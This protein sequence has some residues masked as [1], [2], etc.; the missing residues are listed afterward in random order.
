MTEYDTTTTGTQPGRRV[1]ASRGRAS[2]GGPPLVYTPISAR[3]QDTLQ[4]FPD[5]VRIIRPGSGRRDATPPTRTGSQILGFSAK[6]QARLRFAALNASPAIESTFCLTYHQDWPTQGETCR[7]HRR[8]FL[9]RFARLLPDVGYL[10]LLEF[11]TR[12]A[13]HFHFYLTRLLTPS[14]QSNLA[15]SWVE[16]TNGSDQA[17]WW[18]SRP[19]N[20]RPW[21]ILGG[22]YI[23]K[24]LDKEA[25]KVVPEGYAG[26][27]RFWGTSAGL[28]P[29][30]I[31]MPTST[32]T[33]YDQVDQATGEV[34][35]GEVYLIR[36]LGRLADRKSRGYSR[37]RV[38]AQKSSYTMHGGA[39]AFWRLE[40]YLARSR[41][42]EVNR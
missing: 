22:G 18:H 26:F 10:W 4:V 27:G 40:R 16:I 6:S 25:Q 17:L 38:Q 2:A 12:S 3:D 13:P 31:Q 21:Q 30:P 7:R 32:L 23:C 28:V 29:D 11:Q 39:A 14:E 19:E 36:N 34:T 1:V 20:F 5:A 8:L 15:R 33:A 41:G 37:F 9:K 35:S 24:Y 42:K